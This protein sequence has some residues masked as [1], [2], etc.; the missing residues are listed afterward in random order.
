MSFFISSQIAAYHWHIHFQKG[1]LCKIFSSSLKCIV[2][3]AET[4]NGV[5][6]EEKE[7]R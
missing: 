6:Y 3:I 5:E 1:S 4:E 2:E 7:Q